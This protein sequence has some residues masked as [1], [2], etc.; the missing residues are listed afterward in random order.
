MDIMREC[1]G[2]AS[3]HIL[4]FAVCK[5]SVLNRSSSGDFGTDSK[6]H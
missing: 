3:T 1:C 4:S 2:E 6:S 5:S